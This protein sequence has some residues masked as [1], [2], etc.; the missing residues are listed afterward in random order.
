LGE[1]KAISGFEYLPRLEADKPGMI[2]DFRIY[3]KTAP[4]KL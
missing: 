1:T 3:I 2:K 4:F